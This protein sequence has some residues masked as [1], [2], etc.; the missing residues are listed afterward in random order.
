MSSGN[1][2]ADRRYAY[3]QTLRAEGDAA[4]AADVIA[5]AL[6]LAP[7]WAEGRFALAETLAE[8]GK[9]IEAAGAY[10]DYLAA[11]PSDSMGAGARLSLLGAAPT[12]AQ[13]PSAYVSRLFDEYAPR[14]DAALTERLNYRGPE[15]LKDAVTRVWPGMFSR[16]FDLG[17]GTGLSGVAF[18]DAAEWLGGV[19]LSP[20]MVKRAQARKIYDYLES[21]DMSA[22]LLALDEPCELIIAA[23]VLVYVGDLAQLFSTVRK[24]LVLGGVFAFTTQRAEDGDYV[25]GREQRYS[26]SRAYI[27]RLADAC[28]FE[29]A[30][31]EDA[32][33]R[34]E[35]GKDVPGLVAVLV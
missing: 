11:D 13:L 9:T 22:A 35:A 18:R 34:Q 19:D 29:V 32:V 23:D 33:T 21:G 12:P 14:F 10:R 8:A 27:R 5:Q 3:A 4:G 1:L 31:L 15:V 30:R 6:E 28:D 17:C 20:A 7:A 16:V 2:T 24:K 26:H 25:L